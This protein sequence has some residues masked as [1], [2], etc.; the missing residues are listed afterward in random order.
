MRSRKSA[1]PLVS[2]SVMDVTHNRTAWRQRGFLPAAEVARLLGVKNTSV[3]RWIDGE[4]VLSA[5]EG[6]FRFIEAKSLIKFV[7]RRYTD[8]RMAEGY[9]KQ[10]EE[11]LVT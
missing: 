7:R 1:K 11:M 5:N 2:P 9:V 8:A 4:L 10:I 6:W 3:Y